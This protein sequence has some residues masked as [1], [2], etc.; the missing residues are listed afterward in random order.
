MPK[1]E[2]L[3][4]RELHFDSQNP[5]VTNPDEAAEKA[6]D[7]LVDQV[8]E[9]IYELAKSVAKHGFLPINK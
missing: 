7:D 9:E 8:K 4:W 2:T 1:I 3:S 5:R 6:L